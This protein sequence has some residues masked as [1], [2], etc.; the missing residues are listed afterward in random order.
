V[1]T[2]VGGNLSLV[3]VARIVALS[4]VIGLCAGCSCDRANWGFVWEDTDC[5]GQPDDGEAPLQGVCVWV[6]SNVERTRELDRYC[7]RKYAV[8]DSEGW[9]GPVY[10]DCSGPVYTFVRTPYTYQPTTQTIVRDQGLSQFGFARQGA[11]PKISLVTR[12]D[13]A[14]ERL[15]ES[16][17]NNMLTGGVFFGGLALMTLALV[18]VELRSRRRKKV[19]GDLDKH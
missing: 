1:M 4:L 7:A 11:C 8:T 13:L 5:D 14:A 10:S 3:D 18:G 12:A 15:A 17:R 16:R 2:K 6:E 19:D 9:W